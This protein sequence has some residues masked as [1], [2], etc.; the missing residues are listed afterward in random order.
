[1]RRWDDSGTWVG[2][3]LRREVFFFPSRGVRLYGSIYAPASPPAPFGVLFCNSWGFEANQAGRIVHSVS[4]AVARAGG[5]AVHFHYPG[6]GDSQGDFEA[7]TVDVM[8]DAAVD[9]VAE[10][11]RRCSGT[12]WALAGLMLGASVAGLAAA[13]GAAAELL[14]VQPALRPG[15]YFARLE[16]ASKRSLGGAA[17]EPAPGFAYGYPLPP[18]T[19][20]SAPEADAAVEAALAGFEGEG[21]IVSYE[22]PEEIEGAPERFEQVR[23]PGS[24]RFGSRD[25]PE[26]SRATAAWLRR[27]AKA[28]A[29]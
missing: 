18:A 16:R 21:T 14:L 26:L 6:F 5:V 7:M 17:P 11:S 24:W 13:R 22:K 23:A 15:R 9:A 10:A 2:E 12:R 3:E 8:A 25:N 1:V 27:R 20:D 29:R 28:A 4:I 19:I